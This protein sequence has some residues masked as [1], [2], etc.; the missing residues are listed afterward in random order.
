MLR[1]S[2][3]ALSALAVRTALFGRTA[4]GYERSRRGRRLRR[5]D[6]NGV[7][8]HR[9]ECR[10]TVA[11]GLVGGLLEQKTRAGES[12][13]LSLSVDKRLA[14]HFQPLAQLRDVKLERLLRASQGA[15]IEQ[16]EEF[17]ELTKLLLKIQ[18]HRDSPAARVQPQ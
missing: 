11:V 18:C 2:V 6:R 17:I 4:I 8:G 15:C 13:A 12:P 14:G 3:F 16:P 9:M 1:A 7:Y 5:G 10:V